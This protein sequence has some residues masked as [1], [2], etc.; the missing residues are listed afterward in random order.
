MTVRVLVVDDL[1]PELK[2]LEAKLSKE[3]MQVETAKSGAEAL[4]AINVDPPD[5]ILLDVMMPEMDGF[6]VCERIKA[7]PATT[8]IPVVMVTALSDRT[9]RVRGLEAGADDFLTKPVDNRALLAR[10]RSLVRLKMLMDEWRLRELTSES[11]TLL[12][13]NTDSCTELGTNARILIVEDKE[14]CVT[15]LT[16]MLAVDGHES[17]VVERPEESIDRLMNEDFDMILIELH[18][19]DQDALRLCA[20]I[21]SIDRV[22]HVPILLLGEESDSERLA[23]AMD[24]GCNDY[25]VRPVDRNELLARCRTQIR[26]RRYQMKLRDNYERSFEMALTDGLTGLYNRRYLEAY[27]NGLIER[28]AGGRRYLSIIMFDID[29]FKKINDTHGHAAG[30]EVLQELCTRVMKGVRSFDTVARYGGEEFIVVMPETDMGIATTVAERLRHGVA[31]RLFTAITADQKLE[32]TISVG[33]AEVDVTGGETTTSLINRAD[34]ALYV[35]KSKGRN[36]VMCWSA[37][38]ILDL[39]GNIA[40]NDN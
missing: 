9:D 16:E 27:L 11:L 8:H 29:H 30:D 32:V 3:Y 21:R 26:R 19:K 40:Q 14:C 37:D 18:L 2:L 34:K 33:V 28:I 4:E 36:R 39:T 25:V 15:Q 35:A 13:E 7:N 10:V 12:D 38:G 1:L 17:L 6:E 23:K 31:N 22:R 24:L 20:Q 5:I